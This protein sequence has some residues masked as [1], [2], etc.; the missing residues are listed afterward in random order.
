MNRCVVRI[1]MLA[2]NYSTTKTLPKVENP[3][4]GDHTMEVQQR[5]LTTS[6]LPLQIGKAK[7]LYRYIVTV[8]LHHRS[9]TVA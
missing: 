1:S 4:Y 5:D 3:R 7:P 2:Y 8:L 6:C 9:V